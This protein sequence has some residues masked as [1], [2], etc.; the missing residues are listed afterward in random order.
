MKCQLTNSSNIFIKYSIPFP[1]VAWLMY[2]LKRK[3]MNTSFMDNEYLIKPYA[4]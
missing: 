2:Q 1:R 3:D 4:Y